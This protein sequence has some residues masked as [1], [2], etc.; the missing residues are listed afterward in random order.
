MTVKQ[1]FGCISVALRCGPALVVLLLLIAACAAPVKQ[2][3]IT[4]DVPA[5][6]IV[7]DAGSKR[8]RLYVYEQSATGWTKHRGPRTG[9][10]ADPARGIRE[11]TMLDAESVVNDI[12][13]A[14]EKIRTDGPLNKKGVARWPAFDWQTRCRV[15]AVSV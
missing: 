13:A 4:D 7:Y 8:T 5:C 11:K 14:L 12:V 2:Q 1:G 3:S 9:A 15:D 6:H 10:L